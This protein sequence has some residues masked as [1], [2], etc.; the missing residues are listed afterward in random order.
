MQ[1]AVQIRFTSDLFSTESS[2]GLSGKKRLHRNLNKAHIHRDKKNS[3]VSQGKVVN[4]I[5]PFDEFPLTKKV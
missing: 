3:L 4:D 5:F 2:W 1:G